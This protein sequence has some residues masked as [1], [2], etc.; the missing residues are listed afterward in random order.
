MRIWTIVIIIICLI[1]NKFEVVGAYSIKQKKRTGQK[2]LIKARTTC[3]FTPKKKKKLEFLKLGDYSP[4]ILQL[5][6]LI[7]KNSS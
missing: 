2:I 6:Y 4:K 7:F 3:G 1:F 5:H